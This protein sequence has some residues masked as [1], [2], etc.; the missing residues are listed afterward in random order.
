MTEP[1]CIAWN[2]IGY[3]Q[4]KVRFLYSACAHHVWWVS[5]SLGLGDIQHLCELN[6]GG[7]VCCDMLSFIRTIGIWIEWRAAAK[8]KGFPAPER[9]FI[10]VQTESSANKQGGIKIDSVCNLS[11]LFSVRYVPFVSWHF[12][13][14]TFLMWKVPFDFW[15]FGHSN[16][17]YRSNQSLHSQH[18]AFRIFVV[19]SAHIPL[20]HCFS[21]SHDFI[22]WKWALRTVGPIESKL[23]STATAAVVNS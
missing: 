19:A 13:N 14:S 6:T 9:Y 1:H 10:A 3:S 20:S 17:K 15:P 21:H 16:F 11:E 2:Q 8:E 12:T 7:C 5:V 18:N 23:K 22:S 4:D